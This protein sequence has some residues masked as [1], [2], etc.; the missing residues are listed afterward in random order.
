MF[1]DFKNEMFP[2][3]EN[4][5]IPTAI[6]NGLLSESLSDSDYSYQMVGRNTAVLL[7]KSEHGKFSFGEKIIDRT[8]DEILKEFPSISKDYIRSNFEK[9]LYRTQTPIKINSD[10]E[11][12]IDHTRI[13]ANEL[14]K[15][16]IT[17]RG[18]EEV[19][20]APVS[21]RE[22]IEINVSIA[23][24][25][26]VF[27]IEQQKFPSAEK[28]VFHSINSGLI[29][30]KLV[31][32]DEPISKSSL[33][34]SVNFDD[35]NSID[36]IISNEPVIMGL[37]HDGDVELE[38]KKLVLNES[39][40]KNFEPTLAVLKIYQMMHR[41]GAKYDI[42][43]PVKWELDA[44][45]VEWLN[46][47][48]TSLTTDSFFEMPIHNFTL[49]DSSQ[50][51]EDPSFVKGTSLNF[52]GTY[53]KRD[54][55][56]AGKKIP[57]IRLVWILYQFELSDVDKDTLKIIPAPNS[58]YFGRVVG[59]EEDINRGEILEHIRKLEVNET[60]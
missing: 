2:T 24:V 42:D 58:K 41:V 5:K 47:L 14:A 49:R 3:S 43:F 9:I 37:A 13:K 60:K 36:E 55:I 44:E 51:L 6:L 8:A 35:A 27:T 34:F 48:D 7:D 38:G 53:F 18:M 52:V 21:F 59:N 31:I 32:V 4:E 45:E 16:V 56:I 28:Q 54:L 57:K 11:I 20:I 50:H 22:P 26:Q 10:D 33:Q 12:C 1:S 15:D 30:L 29:Q 40:M 46:R 19:Q 25:A 23:G 17:G 39:V